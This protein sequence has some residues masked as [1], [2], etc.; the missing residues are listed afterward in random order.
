[1]D[2]ILTIVA[3]L[4]PSLNIKWFCFNN[5]SPSASKIDSITR[6]ASIYQNKESGDQITFPAICGKQ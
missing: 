3:L 6:P 5:S 4:L 2:S 1:M